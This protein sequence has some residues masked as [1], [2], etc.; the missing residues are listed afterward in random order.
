MK[1]KTSELSGAALDWAISKV[2]ERDIYDLDWR[3]VDGEMLG[4]G[5]IGSSPEF[6][7]F[8]LSGRTDM[9]SEAPVYSPS[10]DWAQGG[11]LIEKMKVDL[12]SCISGN[13]SAESMDVIR[14]IPS[15]IGPTPLVAACRS[16]VLAKLGEEVEVPDELL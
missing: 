16:I 13:W 1:I 6:V 14:T 2:D 8:R 9:F 7:C 3:I 4:F 12:G 15:S 11:P 5:T 10:T